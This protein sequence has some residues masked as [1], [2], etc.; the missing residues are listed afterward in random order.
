MPSFAA[1]WNLSRQRAF[2]RLR[3]EAQFAGAD[4]V[5]GIEMTAK[6][7][8]GGPGQRRVR[9]VRHRRPRNHACAP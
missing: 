2:D 8:L 9:R 4:A 6:G 3:Q 5:I 7:F 1:P